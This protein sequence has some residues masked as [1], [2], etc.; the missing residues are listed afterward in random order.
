M[1]RILGSNGHPVGKGGAI[2]QP[3]QIAVNVAIQLGPGGPVMVVQYTGPDGSQETRPVPMD[4]NTARQIGLH[5][6][7]ASA[8]Y[9]HMAQRARDEADP[10]AIGPGPADDLLDEARRNVGD[11]G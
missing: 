1:G 11:Q 7:S 9:E 4:P 10:F 5:L 8:V 3:G 6:I 2:A